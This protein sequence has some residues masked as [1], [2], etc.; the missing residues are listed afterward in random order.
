VF[1]NEAA[2]MKL[3]WSGRRKGRPFP[4][5]ERKLLLMEE[6]GWDFWELRGIKWLKLGVWLFLLFSSTSVIKINPFVKIKI[7]Y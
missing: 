7:L 2:V 3:K 5:P 4:L 1:R 6:T